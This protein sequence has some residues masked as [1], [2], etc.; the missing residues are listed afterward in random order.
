MYVNL[1]RKLT[2]LLLNEQ[3]EQP[4]SFPFRHISTI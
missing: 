2:I 1:G 4:T 3:K